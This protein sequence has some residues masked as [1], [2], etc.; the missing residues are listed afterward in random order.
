MNVGMDI[1]FTGT[2]ERWAALGTRPLSSHL[3]LHI[4]HK[5]ADA[6]NHLRKCRRDAGYVWHAARRFAIPPF[7]CSLSAH[8]RGD[9]LLR[10]GNTKAEAVVVHRAGSV[11]N[12]TTQI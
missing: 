6:P 4:S 11:L 5:T 1:R 3:S 8:L 2:S 9:H 12:V 10:H 7:D